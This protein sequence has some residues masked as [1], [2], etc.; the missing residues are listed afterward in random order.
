[1]ER[2]RRNGMIEFAR[3]SSDRLRAKKNRESEEVGIAN[4]GSQRRDQDV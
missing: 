2:D 3:T 1:M 4:G